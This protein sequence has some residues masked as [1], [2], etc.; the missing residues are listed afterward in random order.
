MLLC[1]VCCDGCAS[2]SRPQVVRTT[3]RELIRDALELAV[4]AAVNHPHIVQ[5]GQGGGQGEDSPL[6]SCSR[7]L[8]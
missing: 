5:V 8:C 1:S 2:R 7:S 6:L 4:T 3:K